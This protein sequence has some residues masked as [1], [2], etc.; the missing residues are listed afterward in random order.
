[1]GVSPL[2]AT[3]TFSLLVSR[4]VA[5]PAAKL[6]A[7]A[8]M[9]MGNSSPLSVKCFRRRSLGSACINHIRVAAGHRCG[10]FYPA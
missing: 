5:H 8:K 1:M 4:P 7:M 3:G 10:G 9:A 6:A 2:S